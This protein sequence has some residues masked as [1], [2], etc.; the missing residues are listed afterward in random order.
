[1]SVWLH[2]LSLCQGF[3]RCSGEQLKHWCQGRIAGPSLEF[4]SV[5]GMLQEP[6]SIPQELMFC[7]MAPVFNSQ[8]QGTVPHLRAQAGDG[9]HPSHEAQGASSSLPKTSTH[10]QSWHRDSPTS[11]PTRSKATRIGFTLSPPVETLLPLSKNEKQA[12]F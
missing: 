4:N 3:T 12:L 2:K 5:L 1:M 6:P 9:V 8:W 10:L 7:P 11:L